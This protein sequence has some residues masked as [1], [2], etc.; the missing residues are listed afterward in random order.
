VQTSACWLRAE[1]DTYVR[2]CEEGV[3][4]REA[5]VGIKISVQKP[6][7]QNVRSFNLLRFIFSLK[8]LYRNIDQNRLEFASTPLGRIYMTARHERLI[9]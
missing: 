6:S 3:R 2:Q 7:A 5:L 1:I 9:D 8:Y 4:V